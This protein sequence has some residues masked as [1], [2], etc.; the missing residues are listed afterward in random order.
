VWHSGIT[1]GYGLDDRGCESRQGL[2][3]FL[4]TTE[5]RPALRPTRSSSQRGA[6]SLGVRRSG[7][8]AD[9][10]PPSSVEFK[11]RWSYTFTPPLRLHDVVFSWKENRD[12]FT[13]YFYLY[14]RWLIENN[15][16]NRGPFEKGARFF[17]WNMSY[18]GNTI[19]FT[20]LQAQLWNLR[21]A[22]EQQVWTTDTLYPCYK[23]WMLNILIYL[24]YHYSV[25]WLN[26]GKVPK[27]VW[28][29][30]EVLMFLDMKYKQLIFLQLKD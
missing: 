29:I 14:H 6:L 8:E 1:P 21:M 16:Q 12:N 18:L 22:Y 13:F 15:R 11:N 10:S 7:R 23:I 30:Q 27:R 26:S 17:L 24:S 4:F 20:M 25:Q 2:G 28:D 5:S 3:I 9:H 19:F